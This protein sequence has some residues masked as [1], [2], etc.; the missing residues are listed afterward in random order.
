MARYKKNKNLGTV[1]IGAGAIPTPIN[2]NSDTEKNRKSEIERDTKRKIELYRKE[3][4]EEPKIEKPPKLDAPLKIKRKI[5]SIEE[6][7]IDLAKKYL[8]IPQCRKP[9]LVELSKGIIKLFEDNLKMYKELTS[10][11]GKIKNVIKTVPKNS[12]E[13]GSSWN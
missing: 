3:N 8:N 1:S 12:W 10:L 7:Y 6:E 2:E 13:Q 4:P 11:K 9:T 5:F